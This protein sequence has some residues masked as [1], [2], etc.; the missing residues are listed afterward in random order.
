MA[1]ATKSTEFADHCNKMIVDGKVPPE[2]INFWNNGAK[3]SVE[4]FN[5]NFLTTAYKIISQKPLLQTKKKEVTQG[6]IAT[7]L[8]SGR[9]NW[10]YD[11]ESADSEIDKCI[12]RHE[13]ETSVNSFTLFSQPGFDEEM[14]K[15]TKRFGLRLH[16]QPQVN[17]RY[18]ERNLIYANI[19]A[20]IGK[21]FDSKG[22]LYHYITSLG[23][24][25]SDDDK[26]LGNMPAYAIVVTNKRRQDIRKG[27]KQKKKLSS[28]NDMWKRSGG[29]KAKTESIEKAI[30]GDP[31]S[32][33][34]TLKDAQKCYKL[35]TGKDF[36]TE[37]TVEGS[38]LPDDKL[39]VLVVSEILHLLDSPDSKCNT[40]TIEGRLNL[41]ARLLLQVIPSERIDAIYKQAEQDLQSDNK[42]Q[43][44]LLLNQLFP[45]S[46]DELCSRLMFLWSGTMNV[47]LLA[48]EGQKRKVTS[49][50][51]HTGIIPTLNPIMSLCDGSIKNPA[52]NNFLKTRDLSWAAPNAL[53]MLVQLENQ[54][55]KRT[56]TKILT[57]LVGLKTDD[58]GLTD[59]WCKAIQLVSSSVAMQ[60]DNVQPKCTNEFIVDMLSRLYSNPDTYCMNVDFSEEELK[61][62]NDF[63][64]GMEKDVRSQTA[65]MR[66][67]FINELVLFCRKP[68]VG[69]TNLVE[70]LA[71]KAREWGLEM[72]RRINNNKTANKKD[73]AATRTTAKTFQNLFVKNVVKNGETKTIY[74][75]AEYWKKC[76]AKTKYMT[77]NGDDDD[78]FLQKTIP[79]D[80]ECIKALDFDEPASSDDDKF[81]DPSFMEY[82]IGVFMANSKEGSECGVFGHGKLEDLNPKELMLLSVMFSHCVSGKASFKGFQMLLDNNGSKPHTYDSDAIV[83]EAQL[84]RSSSDQFQPMVSSIIFDIVWI[85]NICFYN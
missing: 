40:S 25:H 7:L 18:I 8:E 43:G 5:F 80:E 49:L 62:F 66:R 69:M 58:Y 14:Y 37:V 59:A 3:T 77:R 47:Q 73:N 84:S 79:F 1:K 45:N 38:K 83:Q 13:T 21:K 9:G 71:T 33:P 10:E 20:P 55:F 6:S 60:T 81:L 22:S 82:H 56:S 34:C 48:M 46:V 76:K 70:P 72:I 52:I 12:Y 29:V 42:L 30:L 85:E 57:T 32:L 4:S 11:Y 39:A 64:N 75:D 26:Q 61:K 23:M 24:D 35:L 15:K 31:V 53:G 67:L 50:Y 74:K 41:Y 27:S 65:F 68:S 16:C 51:A 36:D 63:Y 19:H 28:M 78:I 17:N 2:L 54:F 44:L